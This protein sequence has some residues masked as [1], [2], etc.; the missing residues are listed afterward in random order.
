M[1]SRFVLELA[2]IRFDLQI[3]L[4]N[5]CQ[6]SFESGSLVSGHPGGTE[7]LRMKRYSV[8]PELHDGVRFKRFSRLSRLFHFLA[9]CLTRIIHASPMKRPPRA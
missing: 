8:W 2:A 7:G 1:H 9:F 5:L 3:L 4:M 6:N